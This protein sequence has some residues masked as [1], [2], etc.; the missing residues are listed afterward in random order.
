MAK[1]AEW[2]TR[3]AAWRA[4]GKSAVDYC[5]GRD[6]T[7]KNLVWWSSFLRRQGTPAKPKQPSAA[8]A[9]DG[10]E[11]RV[12]RIVGRSSRRDEIAAPIV[13]AVGA[14]RVE[15]PVGVDVAALGAVLDTVL[16]AVAR[17]AS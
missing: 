17:G 15:V 8:A 3:V 10:A 2:A 13:I 12:A 4:S 7:A 1:A 14:A 9:R 11:F 6:F 16:V 5:R